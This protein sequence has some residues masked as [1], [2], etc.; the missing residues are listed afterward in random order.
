M[1]K[2]NKALP[3]LLSIA[4]VMG[5]VATTVVSV[6]A[7]PKAIKILEERRIQK[8]ENLTVK[9]KVEATWKLYL[10]S[11]GIAFAT[12]ACIIGANVLN[13]KA[14]ASLASAYAL[15]SSSYNRYKGKIIE[16]FGKEAHDNIISELKIEKANAMP[17][18]AGSIIMDSCLDFDTNE[19]ETLFY[20]EYSQRYFTSTI[21]KVLKAE[22]HLNRN[23]VLGGGVYV[24]DFYDFLGISH[25]DGGDAEIGWS[26]YDSDILWIDFNH[27]KSTTDDGLEV[28]IIEMVFEPLEEWS[29]T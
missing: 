2:I 7:T 24:N 22:Y 13:Q 8:G 27:I 10:P 25:I 12:V 1:N 20:D 15:I 23:Y 16:K 3:I 14:Q 6:K 4:G 19:E 18:T 5:V 11:V 17:I 9:D 28:C 21:S 26:S 29:D